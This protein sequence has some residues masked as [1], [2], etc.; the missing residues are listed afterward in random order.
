MTQP[1]KP[2]CL[3][4]PDREGPIMQNACRIRAWMDALAAFAEYVPEQ[5]REEYV[6]RGLEHTR[7][8]VIR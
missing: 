2:L 4:H 3:K 1:P 7:G 8:M 5:Y 6:R